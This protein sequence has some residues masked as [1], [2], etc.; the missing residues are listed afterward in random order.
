MNND[1]DFSYS[2]DALATIEVPI[3]IPGDL[4]ASLLNII[5]YASEND[6]IDDLLFCSHSSKK[7]EGFYNLLSERID[8][9]N[10]VEE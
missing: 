4:A 7:L 1:I 5:G 9:K 2:H 3:M 8:I 6:A 10:R